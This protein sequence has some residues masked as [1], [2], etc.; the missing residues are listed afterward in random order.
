MKKAKI[1][2]DHADHVELLLMKILDRA[3]YSV[4]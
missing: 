3:F 1:G 2:S 4:F